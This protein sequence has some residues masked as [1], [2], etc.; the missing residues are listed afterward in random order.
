ML[1]SSEI[2][3]EDE[4]FN[5]REHELKSHSFRI[6]RMRKLGIMQISCDQIS[7]NFLPPP[8]DQSDHPFRPP[9]PL[10]W[11]H[12]IWTIFQ[13]KWLNIDS[14]LFQQ[15]FWGLIITLI[16]TPLQMQKIPDVE[17][18]YP[19]SSPKSKYTLF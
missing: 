9:T 18:K 17:T 6:Q 12:D 5:R 15:F 11:S 19:N 1:P 4:D 2:R 10:N 16:Y 14:S 13:R 3:V 8:H 7:W